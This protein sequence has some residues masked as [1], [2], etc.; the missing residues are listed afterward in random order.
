MSFSFQQVSWIISASHAS[1][2]ASYLTWKTVEY[3]ELTPIT[4]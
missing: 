2:L 1:G 4:A 3:E